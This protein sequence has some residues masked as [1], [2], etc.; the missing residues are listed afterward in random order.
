MQRRNEQRAVRRLQKRFRTDPDVFRRSGRPG[1]PY[2][3]LVIHYIEAIEQVTGRAFPF[4]RPRSR[5]GVPS[6]V[7]MRLLH[8][9]LDRALFVSGPPPA[10]T[11]AQIVCGRRERVRPLPTRSQ[12]DRF[13]QSPQVVKMPQAVSDLRN[14]CESVSE[15]TWPSHR[16]PERH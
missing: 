11:I 4:A 5:G 3:W 6:G 10:E 2:R 15:T 7:E 16:K 13:Y 14:R 1:Y 12:T 9:A 8:A